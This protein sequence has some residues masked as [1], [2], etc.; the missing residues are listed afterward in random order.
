M[1]YILFIA[2]FVVSNFSYAEQPKPKVVNFFINGV[3]NTEDQAKKSRDAIV[4]RLNGMNL[5]KMDNKE[6]TLLHNQTQGV[7]SD[8]IEAAFQRTN[9]DKLLL[10]LSKNADTQ[11][12]LIDNVTSLTKVSLSK[13]EEE[14]LI[15]TSTLIALTSDQ[16]KKNKLMNLIKSPSLFRYELIKNGYTLAEITALEKIEG[17]HE[18]VLKLS[19]VYSKLLSKVPDY[20]ISLENKDFKK[21]IGAFKEELLKGNAVNVI[22]HSQGNL[23]AIKAANELEKQG[24]GDRIKVLSIAT[25]AKEIYRDGPYVNLKED[26]VSRA[27]FNGLDRNYT[28]YDGGE[29]AILFPSLLEGDRLSVLDIV[30]SVGVSFWLEDYNKA[31]YGDFTGHGLVD[32]YLKGTETFRVIPLLFAANYIKLDESLSKVSKSKNSDFVDSYIEQFKEDFAQFSGL[33]KNT[34]IV[35]FKENR[36]LVESDLNKNG[37]D[38]TILIFNIEYGNDYAFFLTVFD[39]DYKSIDHKKIGG[40][41]ARA[42]DFKEVKDGEIF[43]NTTEYAATDP[44]CCPSIESSTSYSL[45]NRRLKEN[46][47]MSDTELLSEACQ[48]YS[49]DDERK[50][51]GTFRVTASGGLRIRGK[52]TTKSEKVGSL[53]NNQTINIIGEC[54]EEKRLGKH[55]GR[56]LP[57]VIKGDGDGSHIEYITGYIFS[58][59]IKRIPDWDNG[60]YDM[61][62]DP[63]GI[64]GA[65]NASSTKKD[66]IKAFGAK[67]V[68]NR[69]KYEEGMK[70]GISTVLFEGTDNELSVEWG[71]GNTP[72]RVSFYNANSLWRLEPK[73]SIGM[74][75]SELEKVNGDS[76]VLT[77]YGWDYEGRTISWNDGSLPKTI[78]IDLK[79]SRKIPFEEKSQVMGDSD[80]SSKNKYIEKLKIQVSNISIR[81]ELL[82]KV[83]KKVKKKDKEVANPNK[84]SEELEN[85]LGEVTKIV[86]QALTLDKKYLSNILDGNSA[87]TKLVNLG[88]FSK[89][90]SFDQDYSEYFIPIKPINLLGAQI[91]SFEYQDKRDG[92]KGCCV[93][94]GNSIIFLTNNENSK[95]DS[96][97]KSNKCSVSKGE[98]VYTPIDLKNK[99]DVINVNKLSLL[100]MSCQENERMENSSE[101]EIEALKIALKNKEKIESES[102]KNTPDSKQTISIID[103]LDDSS[104]KALLNSF[105][106]KKCVSEGSYYFPVYRRPENKDFIKYEALRNIGI[107]SRDRISVKNSRYEMSV[108]NTDST[109]IYGNNPLVEVASYQPTSQAKKLFVKAE[110]SGVFSMNPLWGKSKKADELCFGH[111]KVKNIAFVSAPSDLNGIKRSVVKYTVSVAPLKWVKNLENSIEALSIDPE[112]LVKQFAGMV[113]KIRNEETKKAT[114]IETTKGWIFDE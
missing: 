35:E 109:V 81:W 71:E 63:K 53:K 83:K 104:V 44:T 96:F 29:E 107:L 2:F 47:P 26:I 60:Q 18:K 42:V 13:V 77:G 40:I 23:F 64:N 34:S 36:K 108:K 58:S 57:Y 31:K 113:N 87:V 68:T 45:I 4:G 52:K 66:L 32:T 61:T 95:I 15:K 49:Q 19:N 98:D 102:F 89:Q 78:Q 20:K 73:I 97:A 101:A 86:T 91:A 24:F 17:L 37:S 93:N 79:P 12:V 55:K 105:H 27:F 59:F 88:I 46:R 84:E 25:P 106:S 8:V 9:L 48:Q 85:S 10:I 56:W 70:T 111:F 11:K 74:P 69:D 7:V 62:L 90:P 51:I 82:D 16:D 65:I 114:L 22:A 14:I 99:I 67:N 92:I 41:F 5:S 33:S 3:L 43:F 80:F 75:K 76:F 21:I 50:Y 1:K 39:K 110:S 38:E 112:K 72:N 28:N 30:K 6:I 103:N 100:E 94:K 54:G